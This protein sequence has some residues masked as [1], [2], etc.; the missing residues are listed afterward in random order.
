MSTTATTE[1]MPAA[2]AQHRADPGPPVHG[3]QRAEN[4]SARVTG[5]EPT[6]EIAVPLV[7]TARMSMFGDDPDAVRQAVLEWV[8]LSASMI[9]G[10]LADARLD[11]VAQRTDP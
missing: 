5:T 7:V 6:T 11:G 2:A 3:Q 9:V 4:S 1:T 8:R 10:N